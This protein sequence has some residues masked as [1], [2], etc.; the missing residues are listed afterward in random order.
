MFSSDLIFLKRKKTLFFDMALLVM[1]SVCQ[2]S[3]SWPTSLL[4]VFI[5]FIYIFGDFIIHCF[6][7]YLPDSTLSEDA[8]IE[9]RTLLRLRHL[10]LD[11]LTTRAD[12]IP[13]PLSP[14][15]VSTLNMTGRVPV[16]S[17]HLRILN[18]EPR[19][20]FSN[21]AHGHRSIRICPA[22]LSSWGGGGRRVD[23]N[24]QLIKWE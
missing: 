2:S 6:I 15:R 21:N 3:L 20:G 7:C 4:F 8:M 24:L 16:F 1:L 18:F 19:E 9:P 5:Y 10:Q 13:P 17:P 23:I 22:H 12:L 14:H 11:A